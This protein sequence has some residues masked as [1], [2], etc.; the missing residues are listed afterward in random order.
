MQDPC[1]DGHR[2]KAGSIK[3]AAGKAPGG[4][5]GK[6]GLSNNLPP[7][8]VICTDTDRAVKAE[9]NIRARN[10][11]AVVF[12]LHPNGVPHRDFDEIDSG[13]FDTIGNFGFCVGRFARSILL[14][15]FASTSRSVFADRRADHR[16]CIRASDRTSCD[17]RKLCEHK[18]ANAVSAVS[19]PQHV[20]RKYNQSECAAFLVPEIS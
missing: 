17:F 8:A 10:N 2:A 4:R 16:A 13:S 18:H 20:I 9:S 14:V 11:E 19:L 7:G 12:A 3:K 15:A 6:N 1:G 5:P